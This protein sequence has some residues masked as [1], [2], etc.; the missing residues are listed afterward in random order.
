MDSPRP[1]FDDFDAAGGPV[2]E[3]LE[4]SAMAPGIE[5]RMDAQRERKRR[6]VAW[7]WWGT[8]AAALLLAVWLLWPA[9]PASE[10]HSEIPSDEQQQ[11]ASG[12]S[13]SRTD[14]PYASAKPAKPASSSPTEALRAEATRA[15]GPPRSTWSTDRAPGNQESE[16]GSIP[17]APQ[18]TVERFSE[19]Q[20]VASLR[21]NAASSTHSS[22]NTGTPE[23][24]RVAPQQAIRVL[25][26]R[27]LQLLTVERSRLEAYRPPSGAER[28]LLA[29][30]HRPSTLGFGTFATLTTPGRAPRSGLTPGAGYGAGVA[31]TL[32][33]SERWSLTGAYRYEQLMSNYAG[34][35]LDTVATGNTAS[36]SVEYVTPTQQVLA[37]TSQA[38]AERVEQ[39]RRVESQQVWRSHQLCVLAG[40][41]V[42]LAERWSLE[43]GAGVGLS[44]VAG[45]RGI[46]LAEGVEAVGLAEQPVRW[47]PS[48]EGS[49]AL[50][51]R[52]GSR[53]AVGAQ[54]DYRAYLGTARTFDVPAAGGVGLGVRVELGG[55]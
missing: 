32:P 9:T 29:P 2:P 34:T 43:L 12:H 42:P 5:A 10:T 21:E 8:G 49:A 27:S 17:E 16:V 3:G 55:E 1:N 53:V 13:G 30:P 25:A 6:G 45:V 20:V 41:A 14:Q 36:R 11:V 52:V 38:V 39:V 18:R 31:Y 54:A 24:G 35:G 23:A 7:W 51:Y 28:N 19:E 4:W 44:C 48:V 33:L 37:R 47:R 15:G 40:Y 22:A 50:L 46:Q 26:L